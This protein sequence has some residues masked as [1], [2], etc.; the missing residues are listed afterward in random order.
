VVRILRSDRG[1]LGRAHGAL[2]VAVSINATAILNE[3]HGASHRLGE[4]TFHNY[5]VVL[6][7]NRVQ[8]FSTIGETQKLHGRLDVVVNNAGYGLIGAIEESSIEELQQILDVNFLGAVHVAQTVLPFLRNQRSGHIINISSIAGFSAPPG[9][10]FCAAAKFALEGMS[11]SLRQ[12]LAPLGMHVTLVE[13][14]ALRTD[15]LDKS[16]M[17]YAARQI[18]DYDRTAGEARRK[19]PELSSKQTGNPDRFATS[20]LRAIEAADPPSQLSLGS[21]ALKRARSRIEQITK[22]LDKWEDLSHNTGFA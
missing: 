8:V 2:F 9:A 3:A 1:R 22:E 16:S 20:I 19:A 12:E 10:G 17:R 21:N 4:Q 7:T 15:L 18:S 5:V 6:F 11:L 14:G 13:P